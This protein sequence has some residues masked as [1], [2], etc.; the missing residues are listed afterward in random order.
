M[1]LGFVYFPD[2]N[3]SI[4][5]LFYIFISGQPYLGL[6][7]LGTQLNL[8]TETVGSIKI[9][10]PPKKE[11]EN[12][13]KFLD[14]Q[15]KLMVLAKPRKTSSTNPGYRSALITKPSRVKSTCGASSQ[16]ANH[17]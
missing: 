13:V 9:G 5:F 16:L 2:W 15:T 14:Q 4:R 10:L 11:Q 6:G 1:S 8:N 17:P 12:I 3:E 7:K